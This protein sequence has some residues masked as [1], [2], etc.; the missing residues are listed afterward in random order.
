MKKGKKEKIKDNWSEVQKEVMK[1]RFD[2]NNLFLMLE[3]IP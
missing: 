1:E 2:E 3:I